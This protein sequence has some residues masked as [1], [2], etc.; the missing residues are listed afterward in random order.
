MVSGKILLVDDLPDTLSLMSRMIRRHLPDVKILTARSG[1][2]AISVAEQ[3]Q[4]DLVLLDAKMP[5]M[6][7][8]ETCRR[9]KRNPRT[10]AMPVLMV[11]GVLTEA[12]D[13][14]AGMEVG[15]EGYLCKPFEPEELAAQVRALLRVKA[16]E[17]ELRRREQRL[18][19]QLEARTRT[20]Q[21]SEMRFR[22]LFEN[23]P[24]AVFVEGLDGTVL[25]VNSAACELHGRKREDLV[26]AK[27]FDLVPPEDRDRVR[28]EFNKWFDGTVRQRE[29][30]SRHADGRDIPVE[31]RSN[32]VRYGGQSAVLLHVRD[33]SS[34]RAAEQALRES[35]ARFRGM[36]EDLSDLVCRRAPDGRILFA[37]PAFGQFVGRPGPELVGQ[38]SMQF[39]PEGERARAAGHLQSLTAEQ[40]VRRIEHLMR[41]GAGRLR[42][43]QWIDRGL[44]DAAGVLTEVQSSGRDVTEQKL[45]QERQVTTSLLLRGVLNMADELIG[46]P[47][48]DTLCRRAVELARAQLGLERCR[49]L[50]E[51][52]DRVVGAY[53][54]DLRGET[55]DERAFDRP[56]DDA[57]RELF[58]SRAPDDSRWQ[59][60]RAPYLEWDGVRL[61]ALDRS[62]PV[63][64]TPI[65]TA[66]L[67]IGVFYNDAARSGAPLDAA[68]QDVVAVLC[69]LVGH[70]AERKEEAAERARL[71]AAVEQSA[72][73][74]MVLGRD[75][76]VQYVNPAFTRIFGYAP[77]EIV[78]QSPQLLR[79]SR[80]DDAFFDRIWGQVLSGESW[81][82]RV[83]ERRKNGQDVETDQTVSPVRGP[84]GRIVQVLALI[85]DV[86]RAVQMEKELF[87]AQKME[88]VG[89]LAGGIAHDFNN[90]LTGILGFGRLLEAELGPQHPLR[91][92]VLEIINAGDR[93]ARLTSRL[94]AFSRKHL[95]Q[96]R[97]L[98][99]GACLHGL[100]PML[101]RT[102]GED[103]ELVTAADPRLG[104]V[105]ADDS[106][107]EQIVMN[108]AVNSRDA[109]PRG[110]TLTIAASAV[111][112]DAAACAGRPRLKPGPHIQLT[113]RDTGVGMTPEVQAHLFEPF[114]T[115]KE[116]GKGSGIGLSTVYA[117]IQQLGGHVEVTTAP[118]RGSEFRIFLRRI[119]APASATAAGAP[120]AQPPGGTETILVV[121]DEATVRHLTLRFLESL[122]YQVR[123]AMN[124]QE[125]LR[126]AE[127]G[128]PLDL[129]LTDVVM[130][131]MGGPEL[132]ER[133]H[134][135][136][137]EL[138]VLYMSGFTEE[139]PAASKPGAAALLVKPFTLEDLAQAVRAALDRPAGGP[140]GGATARP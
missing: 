32:R 59:E 129:V 49:I 94:L 54:T 122:G 113:V 78:G 19:L 76:R 10:M 25:D 66:R 17:D 38:T 119:A 138:P 101:R 75:R 31:I 40:P 83:C 88:T 53:G 42:W 90:L 137:P 51:R 140:E 37:N 63:A 85:Q 97:P 95:V 3:E 9:M 77:E 133:L 110:G 56:V 15:A 131:V 70:I 100:D 11:S 64:C 58:R 65:Q 4:P 92:D 102:V 48:V 13:R 55:T 7:G 61:Q 114:F 103:V 16:A 50:L 72:E 89:R 118:G 33:I 115:T 127:S 126:L 132:V 99:I 74:V 6:D 39:L 84:G 125:A 128:A 79:S 34:R 26:G 109:M 36:L 104:A 21:E 86:T 96:P 117:I 69:S 18:E 106:Q 47:D 27:V 98:D 20:L 80:H 130:P 81:S 43:V 107:I 139:L 123:V 134:A 30:F 136:R 91:G 8:F 120:P 41:N 71:T 46:C 24:D 116:P 2:E 12:R 60:Q 5:D 28:D 135:R 124:G 29:S 73:C 68:R 67:R 1:P 22:I 23:S 35:E 112:L 52:A 108:L 82:G 14:V 121:E 111:D 87:Q 44:F 105:E 45:A 62:G 57:W 93:A